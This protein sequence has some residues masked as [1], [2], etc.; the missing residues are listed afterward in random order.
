MKYLLLISNL[1]TWR[2]FRNFSRDFVTITLEA[3]NF[4]LFNCNYHILKHLSLNDFLLSNDLEF[5]ELLCVDHA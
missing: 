1:T 4:L 5:K 3:K 2:L